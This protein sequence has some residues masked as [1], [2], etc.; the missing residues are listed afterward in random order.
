MKELFEETA[1]LLAAGENIAVATI[2]RTRGSTPREVG[3]KMLVR[4][5]GAIVGT[6]GGGCG[7]AEVWRTAIEVIHSGKPRTVEVDLTQEISLQSDGVCG[8]I[9][10]VFIEAW[11]PSSGESGDSQSNGAISALELARSAIDA[12]AEKR[13]AA[14]ATVV[15]NRGNAPVLP[16]AKMIVL[17]DGNVLGSLRLGALDDAVADE[18]LKVI[19]SREPA[20][21]KLETALKARGEADFGREFAGLEVFVEPFKTLPMLLIAG[22]GHIAV[23]LANIAKILDFHVA[24]VDDRASFANTERFPTTDRILVGDF[25]PALKSFTITPD[26]YV[27]LITRG[28]QHDV[29]SLKQVIDSPA[30][31]IGMIG[32]RRRVFAVFKLLHDE[33]MPIEKLARVHAP[34]GV[35]LGAETPAEIALSIIAEVVKVMRG[36]NAASLSESVREKY[37]R[38]LAKGEDLD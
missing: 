10:D 16:G 12:M 25:E 11:R 27:V 35:D 3:A 19:T 26:T 21:I 38:L 32:S 23:P 18:A 4:P 14:L 17:G 33:G 34:I 24:V 29:V 9:M 15:E 13:P 28:H 37:L 6:V 8:G 30:R 1:S 7:E 5:S 20:L 31:Y 22:A 36:G 2:I